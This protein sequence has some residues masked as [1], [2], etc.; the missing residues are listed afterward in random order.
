MTQTRPIALRADETYGPPPAAPLCAYLLCM[1]M[2][3][4][5]QARTPYWVM[6]KVMDRTSCRLK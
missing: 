1:H 2:V 6:V 5:G 3:P 4:L